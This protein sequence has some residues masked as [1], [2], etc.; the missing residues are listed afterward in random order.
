MVARAADRRALS[1]WPVRMERVGW[2]KMAVMLAKRMLMAAIHAPAL[3]RLERRWTLRAAV[4][5][6]RVVKMPSENTMKD[7]SK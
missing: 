1:S 5:A 2:F 4:V 6:V 7:W 3:Y